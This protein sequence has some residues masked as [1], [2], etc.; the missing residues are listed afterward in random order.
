MMWIS[1]PPYL[2]VRSQSVCISWHI[3]RHIQLCVYSKGTSQSTASL[4]FVTMRKAQMR[5]I[6]QFP[7]H[8]HV[9]VNAPAHLSPFCHSINNMHNS[10]FSVFFISKLCIFHV[11]CNNFR[12][13]V[14]LNHESATRHDAVSLFRVC[15]WTQNHSICRSYDQLWI[16][17]PVN[18]Y[19]AHS[20][21]SISPKLI[22]ICDRQ[23]I[24]QNI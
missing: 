8:F 7:S 16:I 24:A 11:S 12:V 5:V 10:I 4:K 9:N 3:A 20:R 22:Q 6:T 17:L 15:H 19:S 14:S 1:N 18:K 21:F 2:F 23:K 13:S